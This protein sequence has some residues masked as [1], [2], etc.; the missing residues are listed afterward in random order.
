M[1]PRGPGVVGARA[2]GHGSSRSPEGRGLQGTASRGPRRVGAGS[3]G[4]WRLEVPGGSR[5][6]SGQGASRSP[7][8]RVRGLGAG[9]LGVGGLGAGETSLWGS[10]P[11]GPRGPGRGPRDLRGL[12]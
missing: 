5:E 7:R 3:L 12:G 1:A 9:G 11:R 10:G 4:A 8:G 6:A 2:L